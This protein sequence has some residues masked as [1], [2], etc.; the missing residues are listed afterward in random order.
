MMEPV[1]L[2]QTSPRMNK[3]TNMWAGPY[4]MEIGCSKGEYF[5]AT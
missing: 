2:D 3:D 4:D 1:S 5:I